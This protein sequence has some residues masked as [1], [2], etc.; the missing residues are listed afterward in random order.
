MVY[1]HKKSLAIPP[2]GKIFK[3]LGMVLEV[4]SE[5]TQMRMLML[6]LFLHNLYTQWDN[7]QLLVTTVLKIKE[8]RGRVQH[9]TVPTIFF[10]VTEM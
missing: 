2:F 7:L 4:D 8:R 10:S 3:Q 1:L 9:C 6:K 5:K